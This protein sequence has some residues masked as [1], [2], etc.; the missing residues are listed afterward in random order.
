[1]FVKARQD[2]TNEIRYIN[3]NFCRT[4]EFCTI[5]RIEAVIDDGY[6]E[7]AFYYIEGEEVEKVRKF[8]KGEL[9]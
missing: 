1:M 8:L 3:L 2:E 7:T 6:Y 9:K 5:E 4:L